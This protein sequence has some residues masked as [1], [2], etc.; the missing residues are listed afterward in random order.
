[1]KTR[2][3]ELI[4][5]YCLKKSIISPLE[6][7]KISIFL[8][9]LLKLI[10]SI[11]FF[12]FLLPRK[13]PS[14]IQ[15]YNY[16]Y[17]TSFL[18]KI[19][20]NPI[21]GNPMND[22][23][24]GYLLDGKIKSSVL[25]HG[26]FIDWTSFPAGLWG[27]YAYL[28]HIGFMA[29]VPGH[30]SL[31]KFNWN[32]ISL[33]LDGINKN[34]WATSEGYNEW[35][36]NVDGKFVDIA[37]NI[38]ND[39]G[40]LCTKTTAIE[41]DIFTSFKDCLYQIN[42]ESE[43]IY[44]FLETE[45]NNPNHTISKTGFVYPWGKRPKLIERL[46]EFDWY[47]YGEDQEEW[48]ED[49][50]YIFFGYSVSESWFSE[51]F[52]TNSDWQPVTKSRENTHN[53]QLSAG[54]IFGN[55]IYT[56]ENDSYPVLAHSKYTESWP[57]KYNSEKGSYEPFWPGWYAKEYYGN[58]P[59]KW[60]DENIDN[61]NGTRKD[62]D[63]WKESPGRFI[64][65]NDV[66]LEFDDRWAHRGNLISDNEYQQRGYPL[67]LKVM[68]EAH[69][70][71]VA[72][73]ED[74]MFFTV[75][76]RNESGA[77]TDENGQYHQGMVM[78]DGTRL[79]GGEGFD[80]EKVFLGFY[81]DSIIVWADYLQNYGVSS[82]TDDY[83][84]YYWD[85]V[86][87]DGDSLLISLAMTYDYDGNS[88]GATN[89]GIA[90]AQLLDTPLATDPIDLNKDGV[91]DIYP[92]EPLK[93][94]DWH[95]FDWYNR[96]GVV[97]RESNSNCC[98]GYPG[99][100]QAQNK[101]AIHY[102]M[103]AGDTTNLSENEKKWFFHTANPARDSDHELNPHFDSLDG[104]LDEPVFS[105]GQ[106]GFDC[107]FIMSSGPFDLKVGETVPFS[108]SIIFGEDKED[109]ITNA[110]FA[111]LMYNSNYQGFT[112]PKTPI[113][114]SKFSNNEITLTWDNSSIYSKDVLTGYSD[115]EGYRIY[116]S[117][118]GG[119]TW[120][121]IVDRIYDQ[122]GNFYSWRP[123][124]QFDLT[125][126]QD[127]THCL[128]GFTYDG[129]I[130]GLFRGESIHGEDPYAPWIDLGNNSGLPDINEFNQF[131]FID[132]NVINGLEYTYSVT[133]YDMGISPR[134]IN[135]AQ[136][137]NGD[138][139]SD[140]TYI[141]NPDKWG[142]PNGYS[143]I[144]SPKGTTIHDSNFVTVTPGNQPHTKPLNIKVVP[145]P[146]VAHSNFNETEHIR[147]IYFTN[148]PSKCKITVYTVNAEKVA[149]LYHDSLTSG[150][151]DWDMRTINNQEVSP[152]LYLFSV[153]TDI[154][155]FI[156]KFAIIR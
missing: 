64:S 133:A 41:A 24:K 30:L 100:P 98:A 19:G 92:G 10:I 119:Q 126:K 38:K 56:D 127:S 105:Q 40:E 146:Y 97:D 109:L 91:I 36:E 67:G 59:E 121:G 66:Y 112:P 54:D 50:E 62:K 137:G 23:A 43:E 116:R 12:T 86:Y 52:P 136:T 25:N 37:F 131:V 103:M 155:K 153:E 33:N 107:I 27:D 128:K 154:D 49:D 4:V 44:L 34:Y 152:G 118:D 130:D 70:Y 39:N 96:P 63:C 22:R 28:P 75:N 18:E 61:C 124:A 129:C 21:P 85:K 31:A 93:M 81:F 150:D 104:L 46:A 141:A 65:D 122:N 151:M 6:I 42:H 3:I 113:V 7:Y 17:P 94:T 80:Y 88:N 87:H 47:D 79:N 57:K 73:A 82:N 114:S 8:F 29:G 135:Y 20:D 110:E 142:R 51:G 60:V 132:S 125:A 144:E 76:I 139:L 148:L 1:M 95:W 123:Y 58:Q 90:A 101:E 71:G 143:S 26:N 115:F 72:Y 106:E 5:Y 15:E 156:G 69:S 14:E 2:V 55:T 138:F 84:E 35:F 134:N 16:D 32:S 78:P 53:S 99:R 13:L 111:Q 89:I 68:A 102:K 147:K 149:T 74:I 140:T 9:M 108:F 77:W 120:G 145:N 45:F 48:T 117:G 83:M 11:L